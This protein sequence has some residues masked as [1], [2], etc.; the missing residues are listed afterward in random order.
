MGNCD[1]CGGDCALYE[2]EGL[3]LCDACFFAQEVEDEDDDEV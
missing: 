2:F 3:D 1:L